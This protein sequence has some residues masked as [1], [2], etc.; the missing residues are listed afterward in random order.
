M[1]SF[2]KYVTAQNAPAWRDEIFAALGGHCAPVKHPPNQWSLEREAD[3]ERIRLWIRDAV[4]PGSDLAQVY[5]KLEPCLSLEEDIVAS[6]PAFE[7]TPCFGSLEAHY[8]L[9]MLWRVLLRRYA[10]AEARQV[11]A[12][13]A[14]GE[15]LHWRF[16]RGASYC[17]P[18]LFVGVLLGFFTLGAS[19]SVTDAILTLRLH[20]WWPVPV[21]CVVLV[22]LLAVTD[23]ERRVGRIH[24]K[25]I[26]A[27]SAWIVAFAA[28]YAGLL[29][30]IVYWAAS[31]MG[32]APCR[33]GPV[34]V[35]WAS[36]AL[37][38]GFV[39]QLFWQDRSIGEPL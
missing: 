7:K 23:V 35:M 11:G 27:R 5:R 17:Y 8:S 4:N 18:R 15:P 12:L 6:L 13:L 1:D 21:G 38:L 3:L 16:K 39:F 31:A 20:A 29:A 22:A 33:F 10:L 28:L 34:P 30:G 24:G 26:I 9:R 14:P 36:V 25:K 32:L 2:L 37:V 19:S